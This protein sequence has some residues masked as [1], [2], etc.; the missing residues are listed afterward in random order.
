MT[1][2]PGNLKKII[3][4]NY[5]SPDFWFSLKILSAIE[6]RKYCQW[7][8]AQMTLSPP[9]IMG[10]RVRSWA[11]TTTTIIIIKK[12]RKSLQNLDDLI[13]LGILICMYYLEQTWW[14]TQIG[15]SGQFICASE[16]FFFHLLWCDFQVKSSSKPSIYL[17]KS[18]ALCMLATCYSSLI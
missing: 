2:F 8:L 15:R 1:I 11:T 17:R 9:I 12:L 14:L 10:W 3:Q 7:A 6:Q 4:R 16:M 5:S 13:I 18:H